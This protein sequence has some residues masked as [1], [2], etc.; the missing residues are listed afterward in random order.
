MRLLH[1]GMLISSYDIVRRLPNAD[2]ARIRTSS[3]QSLPLHGYMGI[4]AA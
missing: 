3:G 1:T 4:V 2:E